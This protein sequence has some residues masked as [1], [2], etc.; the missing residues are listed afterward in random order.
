VPGKDVDL[1]AREQPAQGRHC[2]RETD[3]CILHRTGHV[4]R[5]DAS[6]EVA[7]LVGTVGDDNGAGE[8]VGEQRAEN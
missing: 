6:D 4:D 1:A 2:G 3:A 7:A 8:G 5:E